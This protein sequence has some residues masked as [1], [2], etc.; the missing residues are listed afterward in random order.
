MI[1]RDFIP[2]FMSTF[3]ELTNTHSKSQTN[4]FSHPISKSFVTFTDFRQKRNFQTRTTALW[5]NMLIYDFCQFFKVSGSCQNQ[6]H[7][8]TRT[9]IRCDSEVVSLQCRALANSLLGE[10]FNE[11]LLSLPRATLTVRDVFSRTSPFFIYKGNGGSN[12][13]TTVH[14]IAN[15][16][17]LII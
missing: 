3:H 13:R 10:N 2:L 7:L 12:P 9:K 6:I 8:Y 4:T 1:T 5:R 17:V 16:T 11:R 15:N 14:H